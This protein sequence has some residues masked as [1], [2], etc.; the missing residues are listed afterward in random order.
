MMFFK[1]LLLVSPLIITGSGYARAEDTATA[2]FSSTD[3]GVT[4]PQI[5][6]R[7][8]SVAFI[9]NGMT[10]DEIKAAMDQYAGM[11]VSVTGEPD[12][13]TSSTVNGI[14]HTVSVPV[15][16]QAITGK[17]TELNKHPADGVTPDHNTINVSATVWGN[18]RIERINYEIIWSDQHYLGPPMQSVANQVG[19]DFGEPLIKPSNELRLFYCYD[20]KK[21]QLNDAVCNNNISVTVEARQCVDPKT[22]YSLTQRGGSMYDGLICGL[23]IRYYDDRVNK[24]FMA[25]GGKTYAKFLELYGKPDH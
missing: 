12:I 19:K 24:A 18:L 16:R 23:A 21:N 9:H 6:P 13:R 17:L 3:M 5:A 1:G 11:A 2:T 10:F 8:L 25:L 22:M 7:D 14:P 20:S 4:L 15:P